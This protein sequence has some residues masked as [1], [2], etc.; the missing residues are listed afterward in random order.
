MSS[1]TGLQLNQWKRHDMFWKA[2][3]AQARIRLVKHHPV[4]QVVQSISRSD[5]CSRAC[6]LIMHDQ[7]RL[8]KRLVIR[9][10]KGYIMQKASGPDN[11]VNVL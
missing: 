2:N 4:V 1:N 3:E 10:K 5:G 9:L 6:L 7:R 8:A 11:Q